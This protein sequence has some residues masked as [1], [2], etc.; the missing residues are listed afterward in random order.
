MLWTSRKRICSLERYNKQLSDDNVRL[1]EANLKLH[2]EIEHLEEEKSC[3]TKEK[4]ELESKLSF[5][6][7]QVETLSKAHLNAEESI[8]ALLDLLTPREPHPEE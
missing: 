6:R 3:V 5:I 2:K 7:H 1:S 4:W 8:I